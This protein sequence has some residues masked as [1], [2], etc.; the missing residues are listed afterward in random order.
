MPM[1]S[2]NAYGLRPMPMVSANVYSLRHGIF[3]FKCK[4]GM[5]IGF[6]LAYAIF[7]HKIV[8]GP[9]EEKKKDQ[10]IYCISSI[11][12]TFSRI[13]IFWAKNVPKNMR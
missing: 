13:N 12:L 2:A 9:D 8:I 6:C 7:L 5:H 1:V 4:P 10:L 11:K 3:R